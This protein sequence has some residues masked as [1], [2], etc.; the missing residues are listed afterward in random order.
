M[1]IGGIEMDNKKERETYSLTVGKDNTIK[2]FVE[3]FYILPRDNSFTEEQR[4]F[5]EENSCYISNPIIAAG[6]NGYIV[7][8]KGKKL[9]A[10]QVE[11]IKNDTASYRAKAKKYKLSLGTISKIMNDK[12]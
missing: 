3:R 8:R 10:E 4:K 11:Q 5:L 6:K 1:N 7:F 9:S 12:Y 2:Q